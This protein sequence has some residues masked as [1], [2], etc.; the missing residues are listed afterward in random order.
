VSGSEYVSAPVSSVIGFDEYQI[1]ADR[2]RAHDLSDRDALA[3]ASLGLVGEGGECADHVKK[4]LFHGHALDRDK[5]KK[6]L[7]DVLWYVAILAKEVG[8]PLSEVAEGNVAKLRARYP[9]G[10][11]T[12]DSI[13]R[14]D[15][16]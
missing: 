2:T 8:I 13:A 6:E 14:R 3:M 4:H 16:G 12:A 7:G 15:G 5:V 9:D 1:A 11:S 10:F